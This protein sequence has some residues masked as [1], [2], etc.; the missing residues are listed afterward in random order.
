VKG[1]TLWDITQ[2]SPI[3]SELAYYLFALFTLRSWRWKQYVPPKR[4]CISTGLHEVTYQKT[5]LFIVTA[6]RTLNSIT[7][8]SRTVLEKLIV[9]HL[10][11][12]FADF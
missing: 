4:C 6:V 9:T 2:F 12:K 11:T 7:H 8:W 1:N 5:V 10:V 3:E